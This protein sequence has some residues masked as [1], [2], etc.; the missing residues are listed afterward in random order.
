MAAG[1]GVTAPAHAEVAMT[2]HVVQELCT[3]CVKSNSCEYIPTWGK[4]L[5]CLD[6]QT[7]RTTGGTKLIMKDRASSPREPEPAA[8]T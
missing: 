1:A 4:L 8:L 6:R 3:D 5:R 2:S 7:A